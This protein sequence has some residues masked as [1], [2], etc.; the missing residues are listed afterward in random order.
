MAQEIGTLDEVSM[1][2]LDKNFA[3]QNKW[4]MLV[5]M[6]N[7]N[8][9]KYRNL[10]LQLTRFT[11]PQ[12]VVGSTST[13]FKGY[14][15][16]MPTGIMNA[17]SREITINYIIDEKWESYRSLFAWSA[18][19]GVLVPTNS[20]D[21]HTASMYGSTYPTSN[22]AITSNFL[23]CRI[24][25]IDNYKNRIIDFMFHDCWI[26]NFAD[27]ALDYANASEVQHSFTMAYSRFE[28]VDAEKN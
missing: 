7:L 9:E 8:P 21:A 3:I 17:E 27:L 24:W 6:Q 18:A 11:L 1:Q 19:F 2:G 14:T 15:I 20:T 4:I 25:L 23:N 22:T 16:E 5:P 28:I 10:E 12:M 13:T 26:K